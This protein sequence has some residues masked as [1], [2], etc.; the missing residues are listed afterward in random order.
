MRP[1]SMQNDRRVLRAR[2]AM[3]NPRN[4]MSPP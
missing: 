1:R 2:G 3:V 4:E